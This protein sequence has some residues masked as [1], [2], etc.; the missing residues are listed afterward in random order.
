M[1]IKDFYEQQGITK[2]AVGH[3]GDCP[4]Q[5]MILRAICNNGTRTRAM[6]IGFNAGHSADL[7][8]ASNEK[9]EMV[10]F[11]IG[12]HN[13]INAGKKCIDETY[14]GRHTLILGDSLNT[15]PAHNKKYDLIFIDGCHEFPTVK[16]DILNCRKLAHEETIIILDD[17]ITKYGCMRNHNNG[18]T[19]AWKGAVEW[20]IV[21]QHASVDF[22][23]GRGMSWGQYIM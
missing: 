3:S 2:F 13:Y 1:S 18:P 17:T 6:E 21:K 4:C 5:Q 16:N 20:N 12:R 22:R 9:L 14:P 23:E 15:V 11:D 10:S 8:L 7:F 19:L